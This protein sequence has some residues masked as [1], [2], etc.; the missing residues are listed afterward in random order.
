[1][2]RTDWATRKL[3]NAIELARE[4]NRD[5]REFKDNRFR[6]IRDEAMADARYWRR[7]MRG[8]QS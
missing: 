2:S 8:L 1:M 7:Y 5:A 3:R 4:C 6:V